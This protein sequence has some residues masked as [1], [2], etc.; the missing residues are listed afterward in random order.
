MAIAAGTILISSP[1]L[2]DAYFEKAVIIIADHN[3]KGALGFVINKLFPRRLNELVEFKNSKAFALYAG[4]PVDTENLFM[5][6]RRN[7]SIKG[8]KHLFGNVFMGGDFKQ[9]VQQ[10]NNNGIDN[11]GI[12]LFVGYCGWDN[13]ELEAEIEEGSWKIIKASE[14]IIFNNEGG[15]WEKLMNE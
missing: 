13:M 2:D 15:L 11:T 10:I 9:A 5:L 8:G 6:H 3:E 1:L 14:E 4:G 7:D 12:K